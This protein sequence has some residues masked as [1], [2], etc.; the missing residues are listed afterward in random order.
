MTLGENF[1]DGGFVLKLG[2][3]AM[4]TSRSAG[5]AA[6]GPEP[7]ASSTKTKWKL[8]NLIIR[9]NVKMFSLKENASITSRIHTGATKLL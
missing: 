8:P 9:H 2:Q 7:V 1:N 5:A 4:F 6:Y 3:S